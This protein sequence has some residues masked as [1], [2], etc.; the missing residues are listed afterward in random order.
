MLGKTIAEFDAESGENK[1][2]V[3]CREWAAGIYLYGL[4]VEDLL[5]EYKQ[6]IISK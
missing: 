5:L 4:L 6:M 2:N 3:D 1:I